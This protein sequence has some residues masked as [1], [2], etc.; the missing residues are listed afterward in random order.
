MHSVG[1]DLESAALDDYADRD[2]LRRRYYGLLQELRVVLPGIQVLLG[3]LLTAPFTERF[4]RLDG[5]GRGVYTA[6]LTAALGAVICFVAPTAFH[7][8]GVRT[9]RSMRLVWSVR[10]TVVGL[11]LLAA[12]LLCA[13]WCVVRYVYSGPVAW[14]IGLPAFGLLSALWWVLPVMS[15]RQ[16]HDDD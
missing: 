8:V 9:D 5:T 14:A 16:R 7:R 2:E 6:S 4:E 12:A 15:S 3:F 10:L 13:V 1:R 11:A